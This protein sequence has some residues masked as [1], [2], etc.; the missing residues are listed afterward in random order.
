MT[1]ENKHTK[2]DS[3]NLLD[4]LKPYTGGSIRHKNIFARDVLNAL[5]DLHRD[6]E[7]YHEVIIH[8]VIKHKKFHDHIKSHFEKK[9]PDWKVCCKIC[10]KT[11]EEIINDE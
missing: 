1:N 4:Y 6:W 10:K 9:H 2:P 5:W 11:Y 7:R 3:S 8:N